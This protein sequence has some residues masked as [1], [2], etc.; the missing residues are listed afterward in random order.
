MIMHIKSFWNHLRTS[1]EKLFLVMA[2]VFGLTFL[3]I[4]PPLQTPDEPSHFLRA[5][6]IS[7][8]EFIAQHKNG[9]TGGYLPTSVGNTILILE[10]ANPIEFKTDVKYNVRIA[11]DV[12]NVPLN[13]GDKTYYDISAAASYSPFGYVPQA[14]AIL[15]SRLI[16]APPIIA[17]YM[18]RAAILCTWV[19]LGWLAIKLIPYKKVALFAI[20]LFPMFI[21]QSISIGVDAISIGAGAVF[22]AAILRATQQKATSQRL[23]VILVVAALTMVM[24]KQIMIVLLPLI[25]LVKT[26]LFTTKLRGRVFKLS[27]LAL[28]AAMLALWTAAVSVTSLTT[29]QLVNHQNAPEQVRFLL[30]HPLHFGKVLFDTFFFG[31]GNSV[32]D[33]VVGIFGW[34]DTPLSEGFIALGF[35]ALTV[36]LTTSYPEK[37]VIRKSTRWLFGILSLAYALG[38]CGAMYLLYS[39]VG[40]NIVVGVQG[41]YLLPI[42]FILIPVFYGFAQIKKHKYIMFVLSAVSIM[43]LVSVATII[44]RYFVAYTY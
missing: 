37:V 33:S 30:E 24:S 14:I 26:D 28:P 4:I 44:F 22:V 5:Y 42:L 41:R 12:I 34:V 18:A 21:A 36:I 3:I 11:K 1:P 35:F 16:N 27:I 17:L 38:V 32:V 8:G 19:V 31:W 29:S 13:Q 23:G 40:F 43:F 9:V 20:L 10:K 39:P 2:G 6:Q 25:F 15:L 7:Y